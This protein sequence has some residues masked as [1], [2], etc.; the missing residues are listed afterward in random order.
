MEHKVFSGYIKQVDDDQGIVDTI[1]AVFGNRDYGEDVL[2]PGSFKKTIQENGDK[3]RVLDQHNTDSIMRSIGVPLEIRE[4]G[5]DE[6]PQETKELYPDATGGVLA[7]VQFFMDTPEGKGAFIRLKEGGIDEWSFGYDVVDRAYIKIENRQVRHIKQL[8]LYE[9]SPVLWGMNPATTTIGAKSKEENEIKAVTAFQDLDLADRE[10]A[11]DGAQVE[12]RIREWAG[13]GDDLEDMDWPKYRQAFFWY[14]G[15]DPEKVG[16]Y[17]LG[18]ADVV[19][20]DLV[21][22]PRGIFAVAGALQGARGGVDIPDDDA[23]KIKNQVS[24]YYAKMREEFEDDSIIPPW[25]KDDKMKISMAEFI[26]KLTAPSEKARE[27][28]K[29]LGIDPDTEIETKEHGDLLLANVLAA[30]LYMTANGLI[31]QWFVYGAIDRDEHMQLRETL[32]NAI[33]QYTDLGDLGQRDMGYYPIM[34]GMN[35][36]YWSGDDPEE[37]KGGRVLSASN[38][39]KIQQALANLHEVLMTAG[40]IEETDAMDDDDDQSDEKAIDWLALID[41]E[42]AEM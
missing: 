20:G 35:Y 9:I 13:G 6:L 32:T 7:S 17:K 41:L 18:Y 12:E 42:Q 11:W 37:E 19:D 26:E 5:A 39:Q 33:D 8:K 1:F 38:A 27:L 21:A 3:I 16:S 29:E 23:E 15:D 34:G 4:I 30:N 2:Q 36:G 14:D 40:L 24:R 25:D 28:M 31:D 22:I 10:E